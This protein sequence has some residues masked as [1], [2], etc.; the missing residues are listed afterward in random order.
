MKDLFLAIKQRIQSTITLDNTLY[1]TPNQQM[2]VEPYNNQWEDWKGESP[3]MRQIPIP[4][5]LVEWIKPIP[6]KQL[7][8]GVKLY[9]PLRIRIHII[10]KQLDQGDGTVDANLNIYDLQEQVYLALEKWNPQTSTPLV[11]G[12]LMVMVE[13]EPD[14]NY[15]QLYNWRMVFETTYM[16]SS[17]PLAEPYETAGPP[18]TYNP[19]ITT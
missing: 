4:C 3:K 1:E 5:V 15:N 8:S 17:H 13:Q 2:Y 16:D 9:E 14:E 7:G 12:S 10:Q 11:K 18:I 19:T 6:V